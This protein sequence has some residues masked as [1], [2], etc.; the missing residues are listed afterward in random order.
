[1]KRGTRAFS[2]V[3]TEDSDISSCCEM[4]DEPAFK[5]LK[6]NQA[7]NLVRASSC[8]FHLRQQTQGPSHIPVAERSLLLR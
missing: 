6:G 1:M 4:K 7:L 5:S 8:P 3:S 2:R